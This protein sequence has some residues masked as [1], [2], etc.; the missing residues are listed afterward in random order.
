MVDNFDNG[1]KAIDVKAVSEKHNA[2][3]FNQPPLRSFYLDLCHSG[4]FKLGMI[5][6]YSSASV[7]RYNSTDLH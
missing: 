5:S 7:E 2:A 1:S 6:K 4:D 3:H